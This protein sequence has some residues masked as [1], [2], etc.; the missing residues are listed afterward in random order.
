MFYPN[1][2][3]FMYQFQIRA[4]TDLGS[5]IVLVG[6]P[7]E[8]GAWQ[9]DNAIFLRTHKSLYP[10]WQTPQPIQITSTN[11][12]FYKYLIRQADGSL[13]WEAGNNRQ[14]PADGEQAIMVDDGGFGYMQPY[15]YGYELDSLIEQPLPSHNLNSGKAGLKIAVIGSS[16]AAGQKAWLRHGWVKLLGD[17]L[18]LD[19]G[20]QVINLSEAGANV[21]RTIH[22]F[23]DVVA[24]LQPDIVIIALSLGNEGFATCPPHHRRAIKRRFEGGLQQLIKMTLAIGAMPILGG[25][26]PHNDYESAHQHMLGETDRRMASWGVPVLDWLAQIADGQ[27]RWLPNISFDPAHP[28]SLGHLKMY[29]AI[30]PQIPEIFTVTKSQIHEMLQLWSQQTTVYEDINGF[31]LF[32]EPDQVKT[33]KILNPSPYPYQIAPYW[34]ELQTALQAQSQLISGIYVAVNPENFPT[35]PYLY[36]Q[37]DGSIGTTVA[38]PPQVELAYILP[39][40]ILFQDGDLRIVCQGDR[41][42]WLINE[43]EHPYNIQPM[44]QEVRHLLAKLPQGVY[45]DRFEPDAPFRTM[46]IGKDGLESRVKVPPR[47]ALFFSYSC[48]LAVIK[49]V[50]ILPLG[51]RCAV[52]MMLYKMEYDGPAFPFDLTRTTKISDVADAIATGFEDMWNPQYLHYNS[53]ESRI[54]HSKWQGLSFAHEVEDNEDPVHNMEPIHRR[55]ASRYSA[56]AKRFW[57]T[58]DHSD[59]ILFVRTGGC[60]RH[61]VIDLMA[62]LK[63]KCQSKP[64]QLL[65]LSPQPSSEFA[66]IDGVLHWD[67]FFNP[68][69]MYADLDHWRHCTEIMRGILDTLGISSKNLFW[70]PPAVP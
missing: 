66:G 42:V 44:W 14:V 50:A 64:F 57:Y 37:E 61:G 54:Y 9:V 53:A 11:Q 36:I 45:V 31:R 7:T 65:I 10:L 69:Q 2:G 29:E 21:D 70:C 27:G 63:A 33:I 17:R 15:P 19:Y 67:V 55:M 40:E 22:R 1:L 49:R 48:A 30:A 59:Q 34:Q 16:V 47:S 26:Y 28:N 41:A 3:Q 18:G 20:H 5:A 32:T 39:R 56:R 51:D 62:K 46:I 58:I 24:P 60:D 68:D 25:V 8:L 4:N 6:S 13:W 38:I 52:R 35:T 43:S 23:P 12:I